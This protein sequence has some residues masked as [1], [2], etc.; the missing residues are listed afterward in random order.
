MSRP[1]SVVALAVALGFVTAPAILAEE[2]PPATAKQ[3]PLRVGEAA[4]MEALAK[5]TEMEFVE[6]PL[7]DVIDWLKDHHHIEIQLDNRA[8]SDVGIGSDTPVTKNVMGPTLRSALRLLLR[9][10]NLTYMIQDEVLLITT[11]EEAESRLTTK[12]LDVSDLVVC[13]DKDDDLW[14]DYDTLI[15][16]ITISIKPTTWDQVG[17]PGAI[18]GASLGTAKVLIVS[19][20]QEV[21]EDIAPLLAAIREIAKKNPDEGPPR[22]DKSI[23]R[24][25]PDIDSFGTS[26]CAPD[27]RRK[28]E[29]P[30]KDQ[31]AAPEPA[32][33]PGSRGG[34]MGMF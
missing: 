8:L 5:P 19:Q 34:G 26:D 2:K 22:R 30:E 28:K 18:T 16:V 25:K 29:S 1:F 27:T 3:P 4:I 7:S 14:D 21:H 6:T 33:K 23:I 10:L 17:G 15:D 32:K 9:D 24:P 11:L 13:R 12:V 20:T 31:P